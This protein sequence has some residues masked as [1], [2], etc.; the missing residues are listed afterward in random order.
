MEIIH[1]VVFRAGKGGGNPC[2]VTIDADRLLP[3]EMQEMTR[4]Y[5][6]EAT[7]VSAS[8][9]PDCDWKVRYFTP[10]HEMG[11]CMHGT[12]GTTVALI[13]AGKIHSSPVW[14]ETEL[15]PVKIEW[16]RDREQIDVAVQQFLPKVLDRVPDREEVCNLLGTNPDNLGDAPLAAVATSRY[17]LLVPLKNRQVLDQLTPDFDG[18]WEMCD[19][20]HLTG[21]YPFSMPE[22]GEN[23][24]LFYARQYPNRAGYNEDPATG[25]AASAL[26]AYAIMNR[27]VP[28]HEGW[29]SIEVRQGYKMGRPSIIF[30]DTKVENDKIKGTRVRG[31][32]IIL[33]NKEKE[34][35]L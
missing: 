7:F 34:S 4:K 19:R 28:C 30:A 9:R 24:F 26:G 3:D 21:V 13:K 35:S 14:Y 23:G 5:G 31:S 12:I 29:N 18:L 17:K 25:I 15:G 22:P 2:P 10:S 20:Y 8:Q 33:T 6:T 27:M 1:T 16:I 11:M 32:A